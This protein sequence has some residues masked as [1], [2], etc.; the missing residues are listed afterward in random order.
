MT[1]NAEFLTEYELFDKIHESAKNLIYRGIKRDNLQPVIVKVAKKNNGDRDVLINYCRSYAIACE[2]ALD[3]IVVPLDLVKS[4][5]NIA[6]IMPDENYISLKKHL[7]NTALSLEEF[8]PIALAILNIVDELQQHH[9]YHQQLNLDRVLFNPGSKQQIKLIDFSQAV[10]FSNQKINSS[11]YYNNLASELHSLGLAFYELLTGQELTDATSQLTAGETKDIPPAIVEIIDS[12]LNSTN[13]F[14]RTKLQEVKF[15]LEFCWQAYLQRADL[16]NLESNEYKLNFEQIPSEISAGFFNHSN[17]Y[18]L[19]FDSSL[20][21]I[22]W[23]DRNSVYLGCNQKF[24]RIAGL[25]TP[26]EI[27]GK[28]DCDLPWTKAEAD[29]YREC[30]RRIMDSDTA[31]QNIVET[32]LRADGELTYVNTN[33]A[34]IHDA[35]GNVIGIL[36][37]YQDI[38]AQKQTEQL[39]EQQ[40]AAMNVSL[41]GMAILR[42]GKFIYLNQAHVN[43]FGYSHP[44]ELLGKSWQVL[45]DPATIA[46][47]EAEI[48][49]A[50]QRDRLWRGEI[51]AKKRDGTYFDEELNLILT[52]DN[53]LVFICRDITERK[54]IER[55][56]KFTQF[57][58]QHSADSIF[59]LDRQGKILAVN[60]SACKHLN[61]NRQELC[62]LSVFD[63]DITFPKNNQKAAWEKHWN[64]LRQQKTI[65]VESSHR[66]KEGKI[67]PVEVVA[68]Y[69]EF[70]GK[71]YNFARTI[72][73]T[74]RKQNEVAIAEELKNTQ[75]F[76]QITQAIRQSLDTETI[77]ETATAE[78]RHNLNAERVVI[79]ELT[80]DR[81]NFIKLVA[82]DVSPN[83]KSAREIEFPKAFTE[84]HLLLYRYGDYFA[85]SDVNN[86][87]LNEA[88][89]AILTQLQVKAALV[90]P[91][92]QK[93]EL[94]GLLC[95]HQC[96]QPR[97]WQEREIQFLQK[98]AVQLSLSL[99]QAQLLSQAQEQKRIQSQ[100]A[101]QQKVLTRIIKSIHFSLD[102]EQIYQSSQTAISQIKQLF[103]CDRISLYQFVSDGERRSDR[104]PFTPSLVKINVNYNYYLPNDTPRQNLLVDNDSPFAEQYARYHLKIVQKFQN[105]GYLAIPI[106]VGAKIW[107]FIAAI[108]YSPQKA[109][110]L[111]EINFLEQVANQL[112]IAFQQTE[113]LQQ[114][115]Q[116]RKNADAAN[117]AK[118]RFLANMSHELRTPLNAILGFSQLMQRDREFH[119]RHRETLK[120]IEDSGE[121]LL[122]L[123]NDVL[124]MSKIEAGKT[125]LNTVDFD[126][127]DLLNNLQQMLSQKSNLKGLQLNIHCARAVPQYITGDE[128][129]LRQV[130]INLLS[131]SIKFTERGTVN[132]NILTKPTPPSPKHRNCD[133]NSLLAIHFE[134]VDTGVGIASSE[135]KYLFDPFYQSEAGIKFQQGTGLGLSISQKFVELMGGTIE[136]ASELGK[137]TTITF[138]IQV[139]KAEALLPKPQAKQV[140]A[141]AP[142][143]AIPKI[144][145]VEDIWESRELLVKLLESVGFTVRS[146][147]NGLIG[148]NL[149]RD[150]QPDL[151]LMDIQMPVMNGCETI[152]LIKQ[153]LARHSSSA[154]NKV[155]IPKII[156]LT[157]SALKK[158]CDRVL[159]AGADEVV[160]KPFQ[161]S[162]LFEAIAKHLEIDFIYADTNPTTAKIETT[163]TLSEI[164]ITQL[165]SGTTSQWLAQFHSAA[166]ELDEA[167][168]I[169]LISQLDDTFAE[170]SQTLEVLLHDFKYDAIAK[171]ADRAMD[172]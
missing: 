172:K 110:K 64:Q 58:V 62:S 109:W 118:S 153:E 168:I 9:T 162:I 75:L 48:F 19:L 138:E 77:F 135:I 68:N 113:L 115:Q 70:E 167:K 76:N 137:G 54:T 104:I 29:W 121:H 156:A 7:A 95:V 114:V 57:A 83:Y 146:A 96:S 69:L 158:D 45:Y 4:K 94:W 88:Q 56:L 159:A 6:L 23:K 11:G 17:F 47:I 71:E 151:I 80:S 102:I 34:P 161:E 20:Q 107:G 82:E 98:I 100:I 170:L 41:D 33:K 22:F 15:N 44:E 21:T 133:R 42:D 5:G 132:L 65:V 39:L 150:W 124:E 59:Y 18:Q 8:F 141:I 101:G 108:R 74:E 120:I 30:D 35:D 143:S 31:E 97:Q 103:H 119:N 49:S 148:L 43:I 136:V 145:V 131:N 36:G 134:I 112:G 2:L 149:W 73:I 99:Y 165:L 26:Q 111:R 164:E 25:A 130:L 123:I 24:A 122:N 147:E 140:I 67:V 14:D 144:L 166:I 155:K 28:T 72:D 52:E 87:V 40:S 10:S 51:E 89:M 85:I 63:I 139:A 55:E 160:N 105:K 125:I 91:L 163:A 27:V 171:C 66:T 79:V 152:A 78:I 13:S 154:T 93:E 142:S 53:L 37:M 32:Q 1:G 38:T 61:Y 128:N 116:A 81:D 129:K 60:Q 86:A 126:L 50:L 46:E 106:F 169:E 127:Y 117:Q 157:A 16:S 3:S 12:L 90:V 92:L 84:E